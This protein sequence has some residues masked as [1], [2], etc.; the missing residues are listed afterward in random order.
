MGYQGCPNC[1]TNTWYQYFLEQAVII[2]VLLSS[3]FFW[4]VFRKDERSSVYGNGFWLN[5]AVQFSALPQT[6]SVI[7]RTSPICVAVSSPA[8]TTSFFG[9]LCFYF[10]WH[11]KILGGLPHTPDK[12][13]INRC[14]WIFRKC[15]QSHRDNLFFCMKRCKHQ[16]SFL[17]F[18]YHSDPAALLHR[19]YSLCHEHKQTVITTFPQAA[20]QRAK[21]PQPEYRELSPTTKKE[22]G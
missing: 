14:V 4:S 5:N 8:C 10:A 13:K 9:Y 19:V 20:S 12:K 16:Q 17:F 21:V 1:T 18:F 15:S 7:W 3:Y 11:N 2:S 22:Q 6:S